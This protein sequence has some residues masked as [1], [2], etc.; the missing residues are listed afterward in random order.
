LKTVR[1][2]ESSIRLTVPS[3]AFRIV[4]VAVIA[5]KYSRVADEAARERPA[6]PD[7]M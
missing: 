7:Y 6:Y 1:H 5:S 3:A 4:L 2:R